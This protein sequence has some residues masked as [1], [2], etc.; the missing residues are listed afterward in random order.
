LGKDL[1]G[2][3][4]KIIFPYQISTHFNFRMAYGPMNPFFVPPGRYTMRGRGKD[5]ETLHLVGDFGISGYRGIR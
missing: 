4:S 3:I 1:D 2:P 5:I